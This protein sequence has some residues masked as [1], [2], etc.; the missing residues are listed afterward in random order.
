MPSATRIWAR[1]PLEEDE[2]RVLEYDLAGSL[3]SRIVSCRTKILRLADIRCDTTPPYVALSYVW[4]DAANT[5][6]VVCDLT[7]TSVTLNLEQALSVIWKAHP[8]M[9]LWADAI[10]INQ[11]N[12]EERSNQVSLMGD[13][14]RLANRVL[15]ILGPA[16]D[17][18]NR[19][20]NFLESYVAR[21]DFDAPDFED[22]LDQFMQG[23]LNALALGLN[24]L[25]HRPWFQR[26]WVSTSRFP[27]LAPSG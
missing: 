7:P 18:G 15:V 10:C 24:D 22:E 3:E 14:F 2:I 1:S 20:W 12:I 11:D 26:A 19:F 23:E 13:I 21:S 5:R 8:S 4:G 27:H 6:T 9:R 25:V 17:G 16:L